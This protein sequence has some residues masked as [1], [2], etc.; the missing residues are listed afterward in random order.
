MQPQ[1][2]TFEQQVSS[3]TTWR[4]F[5]PEDSPLRWPD[6]SL[7]SP[8][9]PGTPPTGGCPNLLLVRLTE[10]SGKLTLQASQ[11]YQSASEQRNCRAGI[12]YTGSHRNIVEEI[13]RRRISPVELQRR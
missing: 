6:R 9:W 11:A 13:K 2:R 4:L 12:R 1:I 10:D 7:I 8:G 3:A 5:S